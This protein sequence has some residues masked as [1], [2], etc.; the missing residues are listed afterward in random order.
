MVQYN[1][2]A[3]HVREDV[4]GEDPGPRCGAFRKRA[5]ALCG[6]CYS[7]M[8]GRLGED[9]EAVIRDYEKYNIEMYSVETEVEWALWEANR[10]EKVPKPPPYPPPSRMMRSSARN[11][12]AAAF[13]YDLSKVPSGELMKELARR[14][15]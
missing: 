3:S 14:I 8:I 5:R 10:E 11:E 6:S 2:L 7:T 4:M 13:P 15:R 9:M 1:C 12:R